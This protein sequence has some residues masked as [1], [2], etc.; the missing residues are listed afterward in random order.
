M[1]ETSLIQR[2]GQ[3]IVAAILRHGGCI[4]TQGSRTRT[5]FSAS[6]S[7]RRTSRILPISRAH[8]SYLLA[9][10]GLVEATRLSRRS[11]ASRD[12]AKHRS[13]GEALARPT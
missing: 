6:V 10:A 12:Y 2:A 9:S 5:A 11:E 8:A 4:D 13:A 3:L 1:R 7:P